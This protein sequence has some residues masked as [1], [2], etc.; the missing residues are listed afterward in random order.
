M[1]IKKEQ[2]DQ[3]KKKIIIYSQGSSVRC[4]FEV[5]IDNTIPQKGDFSILGDEDEPLLLGKNFRAGL[6]VTLSP[7]GSGFSGLGKKN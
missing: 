4:L 2:G 6:G 7:A 1:R 5:Q 3:M